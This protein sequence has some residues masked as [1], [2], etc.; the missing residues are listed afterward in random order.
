MRRKSEEIDAYH[1]VCVC[2]CDTC[3]YIFEI[4]NQ[5]VSYRNSGLKEKFELGNL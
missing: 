5:S 3:T 2:V 1:I 4:L